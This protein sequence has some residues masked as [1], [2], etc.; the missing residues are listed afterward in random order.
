MM[1]MYWVQKFS[2][3]IQIYKTFCKNSSYHKVNIFLHFRDFDKTLS[4]LIVNR[5][6]LYERPKSA[7][8]KPRSNNVTHED[9]YIPRRKSLAKTSNPGSRRNSSG[10]PILPFN[11][12]LDEEENEMFISQAAEID[13]KFY[14]EDEQAAAAQPPPK[15]EIFV[16]KMQVDQ[17]ENE[18]EEIDGSDEE[19]IV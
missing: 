18:V 12:H 5:M 4:S 6:T 17:D 13:E 16:K 19:D 1:R 7:K 9:V 10:E 3:L 2:V 15:V 14:L 8:E 11:P